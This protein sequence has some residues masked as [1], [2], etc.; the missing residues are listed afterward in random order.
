MAKAYCIEVRC[1]MTPKFAN[2]YEHLKRAE[3]LHT[4][5]P[6]KFKV[7][8]YLIKVHESRGDKIIV[9]C[10]RPKVI[11]YYAGQLKHAVIHG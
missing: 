5:N 3:L 11:E 4:A 2:E 8:Q 10:D 6:M 7:L 1:K 9:F